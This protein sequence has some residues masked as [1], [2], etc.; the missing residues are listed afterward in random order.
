MDTDDSSEVTTTESSSKEG[1]LESTEDV[2]KWGR[3][4]EVGGCWKERGAGGGA[5]SRRLLEGKRGWGWGGE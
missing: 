4:Q 5:G 3:G 1:T 2:S